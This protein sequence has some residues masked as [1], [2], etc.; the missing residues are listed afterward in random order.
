MLNNVTVLLLEL[1]QNLCYYNDHMCAFVC[2]S[3]TPVLAL[4]ASADTKNRGRVTK[5]LNFESATQV[6][7]SPNRTN[8]RLELTYAPADNFN[9]MDWVVKEVRDKRLSMSPIIIYCRSL[10]Q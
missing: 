5:L 4:T 2:L 1:Y 9:C 10:S 8:I 6:T 3:G 7:A